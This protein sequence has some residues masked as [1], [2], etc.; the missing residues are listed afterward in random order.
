MKKNVLSVLAL[1]PA[2]VLAAPGDIE[3]EGHFSGPSPERRAMVDIPFRHDLRRARGVSFELTVDD[4][5]Q[6]SGFTFHFHS[7]GGWYSVNFDPGAS[8]ERTRIFV[9]KSAV[10]GEDRPSGWKDVD[11]VRVSGW[12]GGTRDARLTVGPIRVEGA[13]ADVLVVQAQSMLGRGRSDEAS[14]T[15][16]ADRM[17]TSLLALGVEALPFADSDVDAA[18][19]KGVKAL[20]FPYN[21]EL[22][23]RLAELLEGYVAGGGRVF[24]AY[25]CDPLLRRIVGVSTGRW[26][27]CPA[28]RTSYGGFVRAGKGLSGQPSYCPQPSWMTYAVEPLDGAEV[29]AHWGDEGA[30]LA[31]PALVRGARGIYMGHV[32]L[33]GE[34]G[35][36][37][38]LMKSVIVDL[39]PSYAA[40]IATGEAEEARRRREEEAFVAAC[41]PGPRDE[42]R[43]FW[44]HSPN[45]LPG[46]TWDEA[47]GFLR[48]NGFNALVV[49]LAWGGAAAYPSAHLPLQASLP[50][51]SDRFAECRAACR[52]HGVAMHVWKVCWNLGW[53]TPRDFVDRLRRAGRL[54]RTAS[55]GEEEW[56]CP[57]DP[58]NLALEADVMEEIAARDPDGIH[59]DY[60]RYPGAD[61]CFCDRCRRRFEEGL[62]RRV[63]SWPGDVRSGGPLAAEWT[64]YRSDRITDLVREVVRR[65]RERKLRVKVSAAVFGAFRASAEEV[66]QD[67]AAWVR[68]GLL[69]FVC[70]MDY[71]NS[72]GMFRGMLSAQRGLDGGTA[73]YPGIGLSSTGAAAEGRVRRVAE[74]IGACRAAGYRGFC[75]FNF[76]AAAVEALPLLGRGPTR[77]GD[78]S[79]SAAGGN[80]K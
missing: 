17:V 22:P 30:P 34:R 51:G 35:A 27:K 72:T 26:E 57:S 79:P 61:S 38:E 73:V 18:A 33:G 69:D 24:A 78:A 28:D 60:I 2:L 39:V 6:F 45:G 59:F 31:T 11:K 8:G 25:E 10:R 14:C 55:G 20:F 15:E 68:E 76:D 23:P 1:L 77:T 48:A 70:P 37:R 13:D 21:P 32:W 52:R 67:W 63:A 46:R 50:K 62:G 49:N 12:R 16:F 40:R 43:G 47:V 3:V 65:V 9:G 29:V 36:S 75:V 80:V 42:F 74:Q 53:D 56:L 7:G 44:C 4:T 5:A 41:P 19:L 71:S 64:R 54:Q 58:A 66:G